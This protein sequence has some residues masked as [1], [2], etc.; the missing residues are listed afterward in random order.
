MDSRD[1]SKVDIKLHQGFDI[2]C[3]LRGGK[4]SGGQK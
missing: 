2:D 4:L 3:G 1:L